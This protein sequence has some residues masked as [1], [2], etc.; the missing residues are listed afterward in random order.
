MNGKTLEKQNGGNEP[1]G[2]LTREF[3]ITTNPLPDVRILRGTRAVDAKSVTV[4]EGFATRLGVD[5][6]D[7]ITFLISGRSFDLKV[8][9]I[10]EVNERGFRPFFY[11]QINDAAF[12]QAPK[13]YFLATHTSDPEAFKK[14]M[15][16][17]TGPHVTFVDV[18]SVLEVVRTISN[19]IL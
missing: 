8:S 3:S 19:K 1:S 15:L 5:V 4:D 2:E 6:G 18:A 13:T 12:S 10:R 9:G 14:S 7:E 11:F 16:A 17:V